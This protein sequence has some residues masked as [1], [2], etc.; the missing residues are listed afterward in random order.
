MPASKFPVL[1]LVLCLAGCAGSSPRPH[2]LAQAE[3]KDYIDCAVRKAFEAPP[4]HA[5]LS[6]LM[7]RAAMAACE[8]QRQALFAALQSALGANPRAHDAY[9]EHDKH[10][11]ASEQLRLIDAA[12]AERLSMHLYRRSLPYSSRRGGTGI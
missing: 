8:T 1:A 5:S 4:L 11:M 7:A 9:E 10:E 3:R 2:V 12:L 6:K